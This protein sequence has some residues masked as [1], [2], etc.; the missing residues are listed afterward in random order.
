MKKVT[1][2]FII[3]ILLISCKSNNDVYTRQLTGLDKILENQP[4]RVLDSLKNM[5]ADLFNRANKAYYYLLLASAN[6][7]NF[8]KTKSDSTLRI[9]EK[10]YHQNRNYYNLARTQFYLAQYLFQNKEFENAFNFFKEAE[11][12]FNKSDHAD[13]HLIGLIYYWIAQLQSRQANLAEAEIYYK[14]SFETYSE[15]KDSLSMIYSLRQLGQVSINKREYD[16]AKSFL[17]Q[18]IN[19]VETIDHGTDRRITEIKASV[20]NIENF[21]YRK[22]SDHPNALKSIKE[23]ITILNGKGLPVSSQYYY[24]I[25]TVFHQT[26][27]TDSVKY[28]CLKMLPVAEKENNFTNLTNGYK[29]LCEIEEQ[30][31]NYQEA[32]RLR[33]RFDE[34]KDINNVQIKAERILELEKMYDVAEKER[35]ILKQDNENLNLFTITLVILIIVCMASLYFKLAHRKLKQKNQ[36]LSE[37]VKRTQWGFKLFKNLVDNHS[38]SYEKLEKLLYQYKINITHPDLYTEFLEFSQKQRELYSRQLLSSLTSIDSDFIKQLQERCS[39]LSP[40]DIVLASA[41]RHH[42]DIKEIMEIFRVNKEALRKRKIRLQE[43]VMRKEE[44]GE[45]FDVFL[46]KL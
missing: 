5:D 21:Y 14:K 39:D 34:L 44:E 16:K 3:V 33:K 23:C 32:Y 25:I 12:S 43:K 35:V 45:D 37:A 46:S 7:K 30:K 27:E 31:G 6:D 4:E 19:I 36:Q 18:T 10:Y 11:T 9:A 38:T 15:L 13:L 29:L 1:S 26:G 8:I 42:W 40:D 41:L 24:S 20:L 2:A 17:D 28:Y 22:L